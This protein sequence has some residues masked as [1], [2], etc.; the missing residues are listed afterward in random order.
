MAD[1]KTFADQLRDVPSKPGVYLFRDRLGKVIYVGKASR[2]RT[3][4]RSYFQPSRSQKWDRKFKALVDSIESFEFHTVHNEPE[5]LLLEGKLIKEFKPRYNVSFR[6][7]KRFLLLKVDPREDWPR[8]RFARIKKDDGA[9]YFGPYVHATALRKTVTFMRKKYGVLTF[10]RGAPTERE[11]KYTSFQ[12]PAR[13]SDCTA[14][15]YRQRVEL[16]CAFLE[17]QHKEYLAEIERE[18]QEAAAALEFEKAAELRDVLEGL[19]DTVAVKTRKFAREMPGA[20]DATVEL[21][22]LRGVLGLA[23]PPRVIEGFDISHIS[24]T[25]SVGSMV[26]FKDAR[27]DKNNYRHFRIKT[28]EGVDDFASIREIVGRRYRRILDEGGALPDAV[29]IDGGKG[30]LDY[31][32]AA[33]IQLGLPSLPVFGLAKEHEE[34][35]L[36]DRAEPVRLPDNSPAS[37]L[38]RRIRDEAHRFAQKYHF[39]LRKQRIAESLLDEFPGLGVKKKQLLLKTFGSVKRLRA[40]TVEEI[41][42]VSGF[43]GKTAVEL[44]KFLDE[45]T[46]TAGGDVQPTVLPGPSAPDPNHARR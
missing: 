12:V 1:P 19:Q 43:G 18:M 14:D 17:G 40:A 34:I 32:R 4:L 26:R 21:E 36:P 5:A 28:V 45:H 9:R 35:V 41:A 38:V 31:A 20:I 11:R 22:E 42:A 23:S 24:G 2:L 8:F 27:P 30:Q 16:A 39:Q 6:D 29:L 33:L 15:Q 44:R 25:H 13:L 46:S 10:G 37:R 3:R 7:D